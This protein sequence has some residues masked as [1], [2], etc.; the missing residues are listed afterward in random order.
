MTGRVCHVCAASLTSNAVSCAKC[1]SAAS[2]IQLSPAQIPNTPLTPKPED[3]RGDPDEA[4]LV[5]GSCFAGRCTIVRKLGAGGMGDVYLAEDSTLARRVA[6]KVLPRALARDARL[7]ERFRREAVIAQG[8]V[9]PN[10]APVYDT[11]E[12][13]GRHAIVMRFVEGRTISQLLRE[14]GPFP[15]IEAARIA[16]EACAG[17]ARLHES[18]VLHRDVKSANLMLE[19]NGTVVLVDLG[20]AKTM[21]VSDLT[22]TGI[23]MGTPRYMSPEQMRGSRDID[24]R[25][26]LYSLGVVLFE[27]LAGTTPFD[28]A[29]AP[30]L[31]AKVLREPAPPPSR[32]SAV[33]A[34]MDEIVLCALEK[35]PAKRFQSAGEMRDQLLA[36]V[37]GPMRRMRPRSRLALGIGASL[38]AIV[39]F[40][41]IRFAV[42]ERSPVAVERAPVISSRVD[43]RPAH[44][45]V[46]TTPHW[47]EA[48]IDGQR[49]GETPIDISID[50]GRHTLVITRDGCEA[51]MADLEISPGQTKR[52]EQVLHRRDEM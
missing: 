23:L 32:L 3:P 45:V 39:T 14:H 44:L 4:P 41:G 7:L 30:D 36:C 49:R 34:E 40:L 27:M 42:K 15:E 47:G 2:T 21:E 22:G 11:L 25:A 8:L 29:S 43:A 50:A 51:A 24:A 17:L 16:A 12:D 6:L 13:D 52:I 35:D 26:D 1:G 48:W 20:I 18:G 37:P 10:L 9:H 38:L 33:S 19:P 46:T 5:A 28:A 31:I